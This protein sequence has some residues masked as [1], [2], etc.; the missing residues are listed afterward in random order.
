MIVKN[1]GAISNPEGRFEKEKYERF[2]DGW[3]THAEEELLPPLETVLFKDQAKTVITRNDSPNVGFEQS[4]NPYRGCEHGC[5]Y[6]YAR[7]SHAYMNMSA[8]LD[9]EKKIFYKVNAAQLLTKEITKPKYVCKPII[10]GANTDPYQ[11]VERKL[12]VTRNILEVLNQYNHPA[13]IITKSSMIERDIDILEEMANRRLMSVAVSLTTLSNKLKQIL[14]PR[15]STPKAR[16]RTISHLTTR[17]ISVRVMTAPMIPMINDM[18]LENILKAASEAGARHAGYT[19]IRLPY[20][21]KDLFKE[22]LEQ[23]FPDRANHVM[24]LIRQM[25]GGKAYDATFG[26]RMRGEGVFADLL[27]KRF[28][29]ACKRFGLNSQ[30]APVLDTQ[31]LKRKMPSA[32]QLDLW[33]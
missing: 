31:S 14:E 9:F 21:V 29:G 2:D 5:I 6:C 32:V 1:R 25:R 7:P 23:H 33:S 8:G 12:K 3:E 19:L 10:L 13:V 4:I 11:P 24:N 26:R 18:E 15:T 22:W 28:Y 27:E 30:P 16:L 20:E 17:G